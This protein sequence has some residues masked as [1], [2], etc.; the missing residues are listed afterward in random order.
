MTM[1]FLC[2]WSVDGLVCPAA[3]MTR[4]GK[5]QRMIPT[6]RTTG[7]QA[8]NPLQATSLPLEAELVMYGSFTMVTAD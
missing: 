4:I 3:Q 8:E 7:K 1:R 5:R 2:V 6:D